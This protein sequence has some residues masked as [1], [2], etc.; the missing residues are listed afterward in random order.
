MAERSSLL[1]CRMEKSVPRVR[2]PASPSNVMINTKQFIEYSKAFWAHLKTDVGL[3]QIAL[4]PLFFSW[5]LVVLYKYENQFIR[6]NCLLSLIQTG[7]FFSFIAIGS[8]F[9]FVPGIGSILANLSHFLGIMLYLTTS[10]FLIYSLQKEK[11]M[12]L[13]FQRKFL[14]LLENFLKEEMRP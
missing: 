10:G 12:V 5:Y 14:S 13:P 7:F 8:I 1:N 3:S 11:M 2:I 4:L 9:T 6:K